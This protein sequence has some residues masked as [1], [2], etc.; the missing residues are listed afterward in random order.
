[1]GT[2]T[3]KDSI[4]VHYTINGGGLVREKI[5][6]TEPMAAGASQEYT[7]TKPASIQKSGSYALDVVAL[8]FNDN[9]C[10]NHYPSRRVLNYGGS[11][12][13]IFETD[14]FEGCGF[15]LLNT[16]L[17]GSEHKWTL[18]GNAVGDNGP[19]L[20]VTQSGTVRV[21]VTNAGCPGDPLIA[22]LTVTVNAIPEI[23]AKSVEE[24]CGKD[25][26]NGLTLKINETGSSDFTY[27]WKRRRNPPLAPEIIS[28][29]NELT[30]RQNENLIAEMTNKTTKCTN[31]KEVTVRIWN[32]K[33]DLVAPTAC[34]RQIIEASNATTGEGCQYRWWIDS[35]CT[36]NWILAQDWSRSSGLRSI[37]HYDLKRACYKVDIKDPLGCGESTD[38]VGFITADDQPKEGSNTRLEAHPACSHNVG[39][40][41][42]PVRTTIP[43]VR[44]ADADIFADTAIFK[45]RMLHFVADYD[46]GATKVTGYRWM[47]PANK[48][49][50]LRV[51]VKDGNGTKRATDLTD[52]SPDLANQPCI[53]LFVVGNAAVQDVACTLR[54]YSA[55]QDPVIVNPAQG[56]FGC[57]S[58]YVYIF[59]AVLSNPNWVEDA[60]EIKCGNVRREKGVTNAYEVMVYPN[61]STG[62]YSINADLKAVENLDAQVFDINGRLIFQ[63]TWTGA[64]SYAKEIDLSHVPAG[65]YILK[66]MGDKG[67]VSQR[68]VKE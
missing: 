14:K 16:G 57:F 62:V 28:S 50:N 29:T 8:A 5:T 26:P 2:E 64:E 22:N 12:R 6:L 68:L 48:R 41:E 63:Q 24:V 21:E 43:I 15:V 44:V 1:V 23:T 65:V 3:V 36:G 27:T 32:V 25:V 42:D 61:P 30:V 20:N 18:N 53:S 19:I 54:V 35:L 37:A 66:L 52:V 40:R 38:T 67:F 13:K 11:E 46:E 31:S 17:V 56:K 49:A 55:I 39:T 47:F 51:F 59:N 45:S 33:A 10:G 7:F 34:G 9:K 58:D 60:P 4:V